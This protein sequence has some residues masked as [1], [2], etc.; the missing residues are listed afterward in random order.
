MSDTN[1]VTQ[2]AKVAPTWWQQLIEK[3]GFWAVAGTLLG[4][5][6]GYGLTEVTRVCREKRADIRLRRNLEDELRSNK[7]IIAQKQDVIRK[8]ITALENKQVLPGRTT[9]SATIIYDTQ[10][11]GIARILGAKERDNV[12]LTCISTSSRATS[13]RT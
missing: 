3:E 9:S 2:V 7:F 12:H 10:I 4:V 6:L 1:I 11:V 5:M 8:M 13:S